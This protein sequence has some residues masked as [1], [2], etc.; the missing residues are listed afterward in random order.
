ME[1][2]GKP[3]VFITRPIPESVMARIASACE[4]VANR[5]NR[6]LAK[7]ELAAGLQGCVG[8]LCYL[9]DRFD[10]GLMDSGPS[11]KVIAN[12]AVGYDNIDVAAA[13]QRKVM[14]TNT[15]DVLTDTTAD[16]AF[17][18]LL[19]SARRVA[20]GDRYVRAGEWKEWKFDLLLGTDVHHA[21]IGIVGLGR[22]GQATARRAQGFGMRILYSSSKRASA[23]VEAAFGATYVPMEQ[24]LAEADFVSLHVPLRNETRHLI[25]AKQFAAMKRTAILINTARGPIVDEAAMVEALRNGQIAG[26]GLDVFEREPLIQPGLAELTNVVLAPH[27]GS[28]SHQTRFRMVELAA[29]NLVAAAC[30]KVPRNLVNRELIR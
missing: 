6:P 20:E 18:L 30:G 28:A 1:Q 5:E 17:A 12:I 10:G 27:I 23:D 25:G 2:N 22:I 16:F 4:V 26:A 7:D 8:T 11:L 24:L 13:T 21:T 3:K 19:A 9:T 14:V 15:P 29:E